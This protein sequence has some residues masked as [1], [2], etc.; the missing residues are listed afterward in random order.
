MPTTT[1]LKV[2]GLDCAEEVKAL[3]QELLP[4]PGVEELAFDVLN[5]RMTITHDPGTIGKEDLVRAVARTGMKAES[6][7]DTR[8]HEPQGT[9]LQRRGR[10]LLTSLSG[11]FLLIAWFLHASIVG[12]LAALAEGDVGSMPTLARVLY[13]LSV[14]TGAWYVVPKAWNALRRLRPDMNLLMTTAVA[15]ALG[16]GEWFEGATV[17]FLFALSLTLEAWSVGRARRAIAAV[18]ALAPPRAR[19]LG[20]DGREQE[21]PVEEVAVGSRLLIRPG[22]KFP[23]D[24]RVLKGQTTANQAPITGESAPVVKEPGDE[25]YAGTLNQEGAVEIET[26][27]SSD[28]TTLARIIRMVTDARN[29]RAPSEQW[30]ERFSHYY[31]P[32]VMA[33]ALAVM[34]LPPLFTDQA[35]SK[36]FYEGLVLLVIACPCALVISTPVSI[37]AALTRAARQGVLVKGGVYLELPA[38]LRVVAFDKTG[39]LTEGRPDVTAIHPLNKT[40]VEEVLRISAA[41]ESRSEHPLARAVVAHA[42]T[43]GVTI[44]PAEDFRAAPGRG[45]T[46]LVD[47]RSY[48]LGSHR[49]MAERVGENEA[50]QNQIRGL[51]AGASTVVILGRDRQVLGLLTIGDRIRE[52]ARESVEALRRAGIDRVVM[53]TGDNRTTADAVGTQIGVDEV[54]AE[55]LPQDKLAVVEELVEQYHSVAMVGEGIND[56]P[57]M[58]SANLGIAMGASGTDV[59]LE[60]AD[61]ALMGDDLGKLPWLIRHSR[62]TLTIIR[63]NITVALSVKAVFVVL[64]FLGRG[65]LWAAIAA[66]MGVSLLVVF[67]ALRLLEERNPGTPISALAKPRAGR[68]AEAEGQ[69]SWVL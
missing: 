8:P 15:G 61:V 21:V 14:V 30:V 32:A 29:R 39:T 62:R 64:T 22:E 41:I 35:W 20:H 56:A 57:A 68:N 45:A 23:L 67:N 9:W 19:L 40:S 24:G 53:L 28:E 34:V 59:A 18:L 49:L 36:W 51:S 60:T 47:G 2:H 13:F 46:G 37:V 4:L 7:C 10:T 1:T 3:K 38:R 16:L 17:S 43:Q 55:L 48:W 52:G 42:E 63:Q 12:P 5:G 65:S 33:L 25:V 6:W 44:A 58:A 69:D 27:R 26:T 31:T 66:D 50:L 11:A 54:Q